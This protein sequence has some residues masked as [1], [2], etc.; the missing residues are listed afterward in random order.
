MRWL[1]P[2]VYLV[3]AATTT[4]AAVVA[5]PEDDLGAAAI[6]AAGAFE[7][8]SS[9]DGAPIFTASGIAPGGSAS[10]T[11]EIAASGGDAA[12]T[13]SRQDLVETPG[14][15][16]GLLSAQ[17]QLR[18]RELGAGAATFYSG[19][20]ATMP[21]L[22][23][24]RIEPAAPR[25]FEF[26]A[27]LPEAGPAV[28]QNEVQGASTM[29][30]YAWTAG[31]PGEG[32]KGGGGGQPPSGADLPS[33]VAADELDLVLTKVRH[34]IRGGHLLVWAHCDHPCAIAARGHLRA[35]D[36]DD[37]R[38]ARLRPVRRSSYKAG[39]QRLRIKLPRGLHRWLLEDP[40]RE[41]ARAR[42]RL[43]AWDAAGDS[44]RV[45]RTLRLRSPR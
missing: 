20:L 40:S 45:R 38:A 12:L 42:I 39:I 22:A 4:A 23:L 30:S 28:S 7:L 10:G 26:V 19:P 25:S 5:A 14:I 2:I 24:G 13:L 34:R 44:D 18:V 43:V 27:A 32:E 8:A 35:R 3:L 33:P 37:R 15:G 1:I 29:V 17:L 16:G 11:V 9:G 21:P 6:A 31:E 41:R 36:E